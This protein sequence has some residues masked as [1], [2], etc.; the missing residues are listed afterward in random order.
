MSKT[1]PVA[2]PQ[3]PL[4]GGDYIIDKGDGLKQTAP[5]T[6]PPIGKSARQ[7]A[8]TTPVPATTDTST[9]SK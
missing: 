1:K 9:A 2:H 5:S 3:H 6:A 8:D 7:V 4:S